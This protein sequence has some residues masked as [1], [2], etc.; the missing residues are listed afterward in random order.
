MGEIECEQTCTS[1]Y[2]VCCVYQVVHVYIECIRH[3]CVGS[4]ELL[5][6]SELGVWGY[7]E[8]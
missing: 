4:M 7:T 3:A 1:K 5:I 6:V 2:C 8:V